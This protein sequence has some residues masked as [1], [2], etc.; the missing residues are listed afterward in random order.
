MDKSLFCMVYYI[1]CLS[2]LLAETVYLPCHLQATSLK[3]HSCSLIQVFVILSR[4]QGPWE[5]EISAQRLWWLSA[6]NYLLVANPYGSA[7]N[8]SGQHVFQPKRSSEWWAGEGREWVARLSHLHWTYIAG[9]ILLA[10]GVCQGHGAGGQDVAG[11]FHLFPGL[12]VQVLWGLK[13]FLWMWKNT[14]W[15]ASE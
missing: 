12:L 11:G 14:F 4:L 10:L 15:L 6:W 9:Q 2:P 13:T 8:T 7:R 1:F 3:G 5:E